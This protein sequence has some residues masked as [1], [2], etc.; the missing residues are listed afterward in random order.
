[1]GRVGR[2]VDRSFLYYARLFVSQTFYSTKTMTTNLLV[3][4]PVDESQFTNSKRIAEL[5]ED[6]EIEA[7]IESERRMRSK[8]TRTIAISIISVI[9]LIILYSGMQSSGDSKSNEITKVVRA[10]L[11]ANA[12][13]PPGAVANN[14]SAK[15]GSEAFNKASQTTPKSSSIAP[16][17]AK[18]LAKDILPPMKKLNAP[19]TS[20][21]VSAKPSPKTSK[22]VVAKTNAKPSGPVQA[23]SPRKPTKMAAA[24][25]SVPT[26]SGVMPGIYF[27]QVGAFSVKSNADNKMIDL[28]S[29]GFLPRIIEKGSSG[30]SY[31]VVIGGFFSV[32]NANNQLSG[33]K[34]SGFNPSMHKNADGSYA[35]F[36]G[37]Y[38]SSAAAMDLQDQLS[39]RGYIS[40]LKRETAEK[41]IYIVQLGGY[42][43]ADKAKAI[44]Q[45]LS[46]SGYKNTYVRKN[47]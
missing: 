26:A 29:Q 34:S 46:R 28:R 35:I 1:M 19:S 20:R 9:L 17:R 27:V 18:S 6:A 5:L 30:A 8:N 47:S 42:S 14:S 22:P 4:E 15:A 38:N 16:S 3:E 2:D 7:E 23:K 44:Q 31:N 24:N 37:N 11:D 21:T 12:T 32:T 39:D 43:S 25:V 45:A 36:L 33:L 13:A 10:P 41:T 40:S